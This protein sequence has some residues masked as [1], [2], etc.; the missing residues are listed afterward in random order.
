[1]SGP[2]SMTC[3]GRGEHE[4]DGRRWTVEVRAVNHR[5]CDVSVRMPRA[6]VELEERVRQVVA[7]RL[8]RGKIEVWVACRG[9]VA[10]TVHV[11][12]GLARQYHAAFDLLR[13]EF[14]LAGEAG[15]DLFAAVRELFVHEDAAGEPDSLWAGIAPALEAALDR[16]VAMRRAEGANLVADLSA[17]LGLLQQILGEVEARAPQV[18]AERGA[19]LRQR[20]RALAG[21]AGVDEARL[22]QEVAF[23]ADKADIS[24]EIVRLASHIEQFRSFLSL[25]EPVGRRL[26]FL[27][28]EFL[29]EINTMASKIGD[30]A[31]IHRVVEM[32]NEVER[33]REQVQNL[34]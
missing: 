6:W 31:V 8:Q 16:A 33:L 32:K 17:R 14:G 28:Q 2:Q 27:L 20:V 22:A 15:L 23:L 29:R 4:E 7:G 9:A 25:D 21:E 13:R 1:M 11:D 26:D 12:I 5:Y 30:V 10:A 34:E 19:M 24:E 3:F 18:V